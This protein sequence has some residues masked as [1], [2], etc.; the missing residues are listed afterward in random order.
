ML[1]IEIRF[2]TFA[3]A[4]SAKLVDGERDAAVRLGGVGEA[5]NTQQ[6]QGRGPKQSFVHALLIA[7][8]T[9]PGHVNRPQPR[10]LWTI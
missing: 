3:E 8:R 2:A 5:C 9:Q 10:Q 7:A 1:G 4:L 6:G